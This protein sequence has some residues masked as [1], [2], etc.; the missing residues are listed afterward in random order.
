MNVKLKIILLA[1]VALGVFSPFTVKCAI[2]TP[3]QH[4]QQIETK[5]QGNF[6]KLIEDIKNKALACG[7]LN[8]KMVK[9]KN[10]YQ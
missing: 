5:R 8:W 1:I 10:I 9:I 3:E 4:L 7:C 2:L 6:N